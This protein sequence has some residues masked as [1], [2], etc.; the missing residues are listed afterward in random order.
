MKVQRVS[1]EKEKRKRREG[2]EKRRKKE[3]ERQ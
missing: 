3:G 2:K 1:L